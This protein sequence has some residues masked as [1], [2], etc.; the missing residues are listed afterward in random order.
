MT[1]TSSVRSSSGRDT[2]YDHDFRNGGSRPER[3]HMATVKTST[4]RL[5]T[6]VTTVNHNDGRADAAERRSNYYLVS[7]GKKLE[8]YR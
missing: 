8:T 6:P 2:L 7:K 5:G 1:S 4:N 3:A